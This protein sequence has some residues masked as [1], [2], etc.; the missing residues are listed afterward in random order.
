MDAEKK[1]GTETVKY[2]WNKYEVCQTAREQLRVK[3]GRGGS[4]ETILSPLPARRATATRI[5]KFRDLHLSHDLQ[6]PP[7]V[8]PASAFELD[9]HSCFLTLCYFPSFSRVLTS[10]LFS[11]L[12]HDYSPRSTEAP[13]TLR[14]TRVYCASQ[15]L[16]IEMMKNSSGPR[17]YFR[18]IESEQSGS[19]RLTKIRLFCIS[20]NNSLSFFIICIEIFFS[21]FLLDQV[22]IFPRLEFKW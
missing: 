11:S 18:R 19:W 22:E 2:T 16:R 4:W 9:P 13:F 1:W 20:T 21:L 7:D 15:S 17:L 10:L 12:S 8:A 14:M 3:N 5:R 6:N